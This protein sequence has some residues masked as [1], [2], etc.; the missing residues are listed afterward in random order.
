MGVGFH[1][2]MGGIRMLNQEARITAPPS[3]DRKIVK[4]PELYLQRST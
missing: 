2:Y 4:L 1:A 3:V